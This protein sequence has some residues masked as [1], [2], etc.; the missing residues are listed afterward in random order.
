MV[1]SS[2]FAC[3]LHRE[4]FVLAVTGFPW[5]LRR[6]KATSIIGAIVGGLAG[7]LVWGAIA[8]FLQ[9]EVGYVAWGV[10]LAVGF[11]SY[12]FGCRGIANGVLCAF[13]ALA[14]I[15]AGKVLAVKWTATSDSVMVGMGGDENFEGLPEAEK[16]KVAATTEFT[17]DKAAQAAT[18]HLDII[19]I[20]FALL[21]VATAF[22]VGSVPKEGDVVATSSPISSP[23]G[24]E[25]GTP[26]PPMAAE[27]PPA[28]VP[29]IP[30]MVDD[31]DDP[32]P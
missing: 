15:Y 7:A 27:P 21:G 25:P 30:P 2:G 19:D 4:L 24:A 10:G 9:I 23:P 17:W 5:G 28:V 18:E 11:L 13:I 31:P 29:T 3:A 8:K 20:I 1:G 12:A 26:I 14:S 32:K 16:Q 22:K 6:M